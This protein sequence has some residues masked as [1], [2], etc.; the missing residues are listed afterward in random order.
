MWNIINERTNK[1]KK[2]EKVNMSIKINNIITCEPKQVAN[3]FNEFFAA[4]GKNKGSP[5]TNGDLRGHPVRNPIENTIFLRP[6][7]YYEVH[8]IIKKLKN[9]ISSGI[10][11]LPPSLFRQCANELATPFTQLIN[12]SFEEGVFPDILKKQ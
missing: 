7:D 4:I 6:I 10:D 3:S 8:K 9:K 12:Q 11:E 1:K 5:Q 2:K